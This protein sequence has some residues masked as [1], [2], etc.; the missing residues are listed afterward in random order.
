MMGLDDYG[1]C[2]VDEGMLV[3]NIFSCLGLIGILLDVSGM[4]F[5]DCF[6]EMFYFLV[7]KMFGEV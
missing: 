6:V 7:F 2:W 3:C 1:V 5:D 4:L